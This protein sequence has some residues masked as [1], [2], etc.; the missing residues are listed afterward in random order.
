MLNQSESYKQFL[1]F[2]I[3]FAAEGRHKVGSCHLDN[4]FFLGAGDAG[5]IVDDNGQN[6]TVINGRV[7]G[8]AHA[9]REDEHHDV[10]DIDHHC[11]V[12]DVAWGANI[13]LTFIVRLVAQVTQDHKTTDVMDGTRDGSGVAHD[14]RRA[15]CTAESGNDA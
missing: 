6:N 4:L 13:V 14:G 2:S 8:A 1:F 11:D 15:E 9:N 5:I 7:A 12:G 3:S 10:D